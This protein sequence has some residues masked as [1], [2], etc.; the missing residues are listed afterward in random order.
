M[1]DDSD[2]A[3]APVSLEIGGQRIR[4][5][6]Q[7]EEAHLVRLAQRVN[8]RVQAVQTSARSASPATVLALV[9]LDLMDECEALRAR[10][11][12]AQESAQRAIAA[13]EAREREIE[14]LARRIIGEAVEEIDRALRFEDSAD[15]A[16]SD[17]G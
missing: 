12:E 15:S 13:A 9:S 14:Q 2:R 3:R 4:L 16:R 10:L 1:G 17:A 8:D 6:A 11:T 7:A 5:R